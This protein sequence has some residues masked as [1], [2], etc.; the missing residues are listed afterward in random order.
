[1]DVVI[2][3]GCCVSAGVCDN[4]SSIVVDVAASDYFEEP[5]TQEAQRLFGDI[6]NTLNV[7]VSVCVCVC[8]CV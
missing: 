3:A 2:R 5:D 6:V 4:I 7:S 8:V 1:M